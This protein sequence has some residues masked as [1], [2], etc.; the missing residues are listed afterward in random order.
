MKNFMKCFL[1]LAM[2]LMMSGS[3]YAYSASDH[4][5]YA[6]N[7]KGDLVF[8]PAFIGTPNGWETKVCI[9]NTSQP[10]ESYGSDLSVV[11]KVVFRSFVF[12]EELLDFFIY[13]SPADMWCGVISWDGSR[14]C[15]RVYSE[16]MSTRTTGG[17]FA[18]ADN[19]LDVCLYPADC[20]VS[21]GPAEQMADSNQ[22]GYVE[23]IEVTAFD[24]DG[25]SSTNWPIYDAC[26]LAS[27][28]IDLADEVE[29]NGYDINSPGVDKEAIKLVYDEC[30]SASLIPAN[31]GA[32]ACFPPQNLIASWFEIGV[33]AAGWVGSARSTVM[34]DYGNTEKLTLGT[35]SKIGSG[36]RN[37]IDE[38]EAAL[39]KANIA[40]RF[41]SEFAGD[42]FTV[43]LFNFPT[44][45]TA[46]STDLD[47]DYPICQ[48]L[49]DVEDMDDYLPPRGG[50]PFWEYTCCL[51]YIAAATDTDEAAFE[52]PEAVF[53]GGDT[54]FD[55]PEFCREVDFN[56]FWFY[57]EGWASTVIFS[58][59]GFGGPD[60][61]MENGDAITYTGIPVIGYNLLYDD[62]AMRLE[63]S[64]WDWGTVSSGYS[65]FTDYQVTD[66]DDS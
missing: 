27:D 61:Q 51:D 39:S 20:P 21:G 62:D 7:G 41:F 26:L 53:S 17:G 45:L 54:S 2:V 19:P 52:F 3:V 66:E 24:V 31:C 12:S 1:V 47:E 60:G 4:I 57:R 30:I 6:A 40:M 64:A 59:F 15:P 22:I 23:F 46:Y 58:P 9:V 14:S 5:N 32:A 50:S 25:Y 56:S 63:E 11:V 48:C 18:S 44:K 42:G 35:E 38:V 28:P 13:L 65:V 49:H 10:D 43:N 29:D 33:P 37:T 34:K 8:V 16:D 36:A 55:F